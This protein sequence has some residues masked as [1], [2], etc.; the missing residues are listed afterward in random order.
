MPYLLLID[1]TGNFS[2]T[3][4]CVCGWL[5]PLNLMQVHEGLT[6]TLDR[7]GLPERDEFLHCAPLR[8]Y[9]KQDM[10]IE[11]RSW[12]L[13]AKFPNDVLAQVLPGVKA[14]S[15]ANGKQFFMARLAECGNV[16]S[17]H[18]EQERYVITLEKLLEKVSL[19]LQ[20]HN[21][22]DRVDV[23]IAGRKL[24]FY[25]AVTTDPLNYEASL[26][27]RLEE[28]F[29]TLQGHVTIIPCRRDNSLDLLFAVGAADIATDI[30]KVEPMLATWTRSV[31]DT[32][33][34]Y[35]LGVQD[36]GEL[37]NLISQIVDESGIAAGFKKIVDIG[38]DLMEMRDTFPMS[39]ARSI[40]W[41]TLVLEKIEKQMID[42]AAATEWMPLWIKAQHGL[43]E[44]LSHRGDTERIHSRRELVEERISV[45]A[46]G[47][48]QDE[49]MDV[50]THAYNEDFNNFEFQRILDDF[51]LE[52]RQIL[53]SD[54][55][56]HAN[57]MAI[58]GTIG[59][60]QAF[61]GNYLAA[62]AK[63]N[64]AL[65]EHALWPDDSPDAHRKA[66]FFN[67]STNFLASTEWS[68][69]RLEG[70]IRPFS[71]QDFFKAVRLSRD[72]T[73]HPD[74]PD[75]QLRL[76]FE[77]LFDDLNRKDLGVNWQF[78]ALNLLRGYSLTRMPQDLLE[79]LASFVSHY[80]PVAEHPSELF[81]KWCAYHFICAQRIANAETCIELALKCANNSFQGAS[82]FSIGLPLYGIKAML[83]K[84]NADLA[85][86]FSKADVAMARVSGLHKHLEAVPNW[87]IAWMED[88]RAS[89]LDAIMRWMPWTYS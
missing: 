23:F 43:I 6:E 61:L 53:S 41:F 87:R 64:A 24:E 89:R 88:V 2:T 33:A 40:E 35:M 59:Q 36:Q 85:V 12:E 50:R 25:H 52:S 47:Q 39:L 13:F 31:A 66:R 73:T 15:K 16:D 8:G 32:E 83:S 44:A 30:L 69:G 38:F 51:E 82:V 45:F 72:W 27:K 86:L 71:S 1:E 34:M 3:R 54:R 55:Y 37:S 7:L 4:S 49:I 46:P 14:F 28:R 60:A 65:A 74:Q 42:G 29:P 75:F 79:R 9:L 10:S 11:S 67:M 80:D 48:F 62:E 68:L 84:S 58:A 22:A 76:L 57:R 18:L 78:T 81:Y 20:E 63:F 17:L 5:T 19:Y 21:L 70:F 56:S 77:A 26:E